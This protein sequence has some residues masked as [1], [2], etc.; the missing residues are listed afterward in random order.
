MSWSESLGVAFPEA[1]CELGLPVLVRDLDAYPEAA[2]LPDAEAPTYCAEWTRTA[3]TEP[4][5]ASSMA[6]ATESTFGGEPVCAPLT[7]TSKLCES[8]Q[9]TCGSYAIDDPGCNEMRM[10][11]CGTCTGGT[12]GMASFAGGEFVTGLLPGDTPPAVSPDTITT[13]TRRTTIA[14]FFLDKYEVSVGDFIAYCNNAQIPCK[15]PGL[16]FANYCNFLRDGSDA[17]VRPL[18]P[19]PPFTRRDG[20]RVEDT[21]RLPANCVSLED[22]A[23]Y[24]NARGKRLPTEDEFEFAARNGAKRTPYPWGT[25]G[26]L[27]PPISVQT[28]C[29]DVAKRLPLSDRDVSEA[30]VVALSTGV[31]EWT[32]SPWTESL[33][34]TSAPIPAKVAVRGG[35]DCRPS[36]SSLQRRDGGEASLTPTSEIGFRCA[37]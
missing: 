13:G 19:L 25:D 10:V 15:L 26:A 16:G 14:P 34:R 9:L 18:A 5:N 22:A 12:E 29:D 24:C 28:R 17:I 1:V 3:T 33:D 36:N 31:S 35:W 27:I 4:G 20:G 2:C 37:R 23:R 8:R 30:G 7:R 6:L 11:R 32:A 21:A